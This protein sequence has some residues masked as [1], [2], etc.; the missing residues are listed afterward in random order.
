[1][2]KVLIVDDEEPVLDSFAFMLDSGVEDF[3]LAGKARSGYEAIKLIYELRPDVVF[4]DINMPGIDGLETIAE[5]HEKFPDTA[6]ILSTAY[7]RFDLARRAIPLGVFAYLVKPVTKS[8]FFSTLDDV[9]DSFRKRRSARADGP[10]DAALR[11]FLAEEVWK[12]IDP[13]RWDELKALFSL[14]SDRGLLAF[15][16][17]DLD[18]SAAFPLINE[19]LSLRFRFLFA[20]HLGLGMYFFPG[21]VDCAGLSSA[22]DE[23]FSSRLPT[24][25]AAM[26]SLGS[27]RVGPSLHLSCAEAFS[28]IERKRDSAEALISE[29]MRIIELRRKIGLAPFDEVSS[30]FA[31]FRAESFAAHGLE[32]ARAKLIAVFTL[33]VD[34]CST[35]WQSHA[36]DPPPFLPADELGI[37]GDWESCERWSLT[38]FSRLYQ[39]A[40]SVREGKFPVPLVKA[41]SFID[42]NFDRQIQLSDA[43]DAAGVSSAY[44]SRL[45]GEHMESTFVDYVTDMRIERAEKLIRE[46]RM[47]VKEVSFAV[48]YADPNYFSKIFR[49]VVGVSPSMYAGRGPCAGG[50]DVPK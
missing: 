45:F 25:T 2:Y 20:V 41:L 15:A 21:D 50:G 38:A 46:R 29:R 48:G 4:M 8:T 34:D 44:L 28:E 42:G 18:C 7:E 9:R 6:F 19:A 40:R 43:A 11:R 17:V 32:V 22:L 24:G 26:F 14:D 49:K 13:G 5:V 23:I 16:R 3:A 31:A 39:L 47:A 36:G 10:T 30:L 27:V 1:M 12:E 37:L 33:L 35:C